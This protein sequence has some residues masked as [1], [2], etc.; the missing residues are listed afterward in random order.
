L[1]AAA[2]TV[3]NAIYITD[4]AEAGTIT[5]VIQTD[6]ASASFLLRSVNEDCGYLAGVTT[7]DTE[8]D[9]IKV[10]IGS[11]TKYIKLYT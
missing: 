9:E 1:A 11:T 6:V 8:S 5:N 2:G 4:N 3:G 7:H 10:Q